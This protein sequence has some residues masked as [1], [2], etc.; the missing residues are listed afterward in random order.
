MTEGEGVEKGS[1]VKKKTK[2]TKLILC[3]HCILHY[4]TI[5][6]ILMANI[7]LL[8]LAVTQEMAEDSTKRS[9]S[10][11]TIAILVNVFASE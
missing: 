11:T 6:L 2:K 9:S 5:A 4:C 1:Q 10:V 3:N 7:Q 8:Q